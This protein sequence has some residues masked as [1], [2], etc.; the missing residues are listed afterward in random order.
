MDNSETFTAGRQV[1]IYQIVARLGED[2]FSEIYLA[3][4]LS[5]PEQRVVLKLGSS[6]QYDIPGQREAL[7]REAHWLAQCRHPRIIPLLDVG[8]EDGHPYL[9]MAYATNG[10]LRQ[11]M[12]ANAP[13]CL[14]LTE[15]LMLI[16]QVGEA[17]AYLHAHHIIHCDLKPE[18]IL[19]N[20][21]GAIWLADLGLARLVT[22][23]RGDREEKHPVGSLHYMAPE[24]FQGV[25]SEAS[26]QYALGCIAYELLTGQRPLSGLS[27]REIIRRHMQEMPIAPSSLRSALPASIDQVILRALAKQPEAR[28]PNVEAFLAALC[29]S[30]W[31]V[32]IGMVEKPSNEPIPS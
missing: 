13:V 16:Q 6:A 24:V 1:G 20:Q 30:C 28:Y 19:L 9:V 23:E 25:V 18:N 4:L 29:A 2:M 5:L 26:D 21:Q 12:N 10:S 8:E 31:E 22:A 15:A 3:H 17:V 27:I 14:P 7:L 11:Q 32:T